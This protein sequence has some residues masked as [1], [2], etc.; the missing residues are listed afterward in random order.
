[1]ATDDFDISRTV[2][3]WNLAP[4]VNERQLREFLG[5]CGT[6][7]KLILFKYVCCTCASLC[8]YASMCMCVHL[9]VP[10]CACAL[11]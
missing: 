3:V 10:K 7:E 5:F 11:V 1:M 4:V 9:C 6:I 2:T 8:V